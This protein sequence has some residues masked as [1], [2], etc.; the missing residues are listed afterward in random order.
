MTFLREPTRPRRGAPRVYIV[1]RSEP[2]IPHRVPHAVERVAL[3]RECASP[4]C[5]DLTHTAGYLNISRRRHRN[6]LPKL[7]RKVV[8][9][10]VEICW[11]ICTK[12][13]RQGPCVILSWNRVLTG[14]E[15]FGMFCKSIKLVTMYVIT[16]SFID[17]WNGLLISA[18]NRLY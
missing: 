7:R 17:W 14:E 12:L 8:N 1:Y 18:Y 11:E 4:W 10:R 9:C 3:E 6:T 15:F 16:N 2:L 5:A 13:F